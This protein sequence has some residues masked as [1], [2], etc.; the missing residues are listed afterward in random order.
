MGIKESSLAQ[1]IVTTVNICGML[2]IIIVGGYLAFKTGWIGY[3]LPSGY[4]PLGLNGMLGGSAVVFFSFIGFD[5]V[6]STAEEVLTV[7]G[8]QHLGFLIQFGD[9]G[10]ERV[11][12]SQAAPFFANSDP[13]M[14]AVPVPA[15]QVHDWVLQNIASALEHITERISA[16]ENGPSSFFD[17]DVAMA[18]ACT[19]SIKG[20]PSAR[21][22]LNL[23]M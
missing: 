6:A 22:S 15:V 3:E 2:F 4:F 19:S 8:L 12:L 10:S 14:L 11:S 1:A 7:E 18:D 20:S 23:H 13:D 21:G 16:K 5:V 9:K 17:N